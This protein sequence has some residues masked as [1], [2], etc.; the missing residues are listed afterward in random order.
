VISTVLTPSAFDLG[1]FWKRN[2][3]VV[4]IN[5]QHQCP[6]PQS[7]V[8]DRHAVAKILVA[9]IHL[10]VEPIQSGCHATF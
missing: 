2:L 1:T 10:G 7:G 9:Q 3:K 4:F 8:S 6:I 5:Q